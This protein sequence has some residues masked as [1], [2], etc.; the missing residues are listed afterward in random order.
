MS[1]LCKSRS[2][3]CLKYL[4]FK[5]NFYSLGLK[6]TNLLSLIWCRKSPIVSE[7]F[8]S[9]IKGSNPSPLLTRI[10]A[11]LPALAGSVGEILKIQA[12]KIMAVREK[13]CIKYFKNLK[14]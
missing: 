12:R 4:S 3:L 5:I 8:I 13:W 2:V 11:M 9:K 1:K 10:V 6:T 7:N 14:H